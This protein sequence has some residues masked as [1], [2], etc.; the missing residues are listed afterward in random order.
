MSR[1]PHHIGASKSWLTW[2][3]QNLEDFRQ[4]QPYAV[5]QDEVIRRFVRGFFPDN[6]TID[7]TEVFLWERAKS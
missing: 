3:T 7:G 2:H 1:R 4:Q 5:A 6:I